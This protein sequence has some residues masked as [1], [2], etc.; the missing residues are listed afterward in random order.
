[1]TLSVFTAFFSD[2]GVKKIST[3]QLRNQALDGLR[4]IMSVLVC[5][6]HGVWV[7]HLPNIESLDQDPLRYGDSWADVVLKVF[8]RIVS[9]EFAVTV[10]F[11][12]SGFVLFRSL[13]EGR[14]NTSLAG[15][16]RFV[17]RRI[18]R[19]Y[20]ALIVSLLL[21]WVV[22]ELLQ[23]IYPRYFQVYFSLGQLLETMS[24]QK[25]SMY[26]VAWTLQVE[27]LMVPV[28]YA[29]FAA[30]S[31]FRSSSL[32]WLLCLSTVLFF[33]AP[34]TPFAKF[35][36]AVISFG[37]GFL[38]ASDV[39][40]SIALGF[41]GGSA[42]L[43]VGLYVFRLFLQPSGPAFEMLSLFL[44]FSLVSHVA[45]GDSA[46]VAFL[47][48]M[49]IVWLGSISFSFYVLNPIALE[50]FA[51]YLNGVA[52]GFFSIFAISGPFVGFV[53]TLITLPFAHYSYKFVKLP[54]IRFAR[55]VFSTPVESTTPR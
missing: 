19:V 13:E 36:M 45:H 40:R 20:P 15:F 28:I 2:T 17:G 32:Y 11:V 55:R 23:A 50:L 12:L 18:F 25:I 37:L 4:G 42:V 24:L 21:F 14:E 39:G 7:C 9:G 3:K 30:I 34:S 53:A 49:P 51:R 8:L 41:R 1:M 27:I 26:G 6:Y 33:I 31:R 48:T 5:I 52:P 22:F 35:G 10:F 47:R 43:W 16:S 54:P 38:V 44:A 29:S 46:I